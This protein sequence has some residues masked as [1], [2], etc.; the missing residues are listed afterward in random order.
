LIGSV[1]V[2]DRPADRQRQDVGGLAEIARG[3]VL[4]LA[5]A[6]ISAACMLG[7]TVIV[8][9]DFSRS[10]AGAF[11]T[12]TSLFVILEATAGLGAQS[13][14][15]YFIARLRS[16]GAESG[17]PALL[18]AAIIPVIASSIGA[19]L[20]LLTLAHPVARALLAGRELGG[21][22]SSAVADALRALA[23]ALPFAALLDTLLGASR[24]YRDMRPTVATDRVGRS[25]L[26]LLGTLAAAVLGAAALLAPL[27]AVAYVPSVAAAWIWLRR[28]RRR[29][30]AGSAPPL[31]DGG[32]GA[33]TPAGFWRFTAP[34][35]LA[36]VGQIVIQRLDIVLVGVIRGPV[37]AAVYTAATRFLVLGQLGNAAISMAA[38]PELSH[39]FALRDRRG[40]NAVYQATTA[41]L[42]LLTWPL[43]LLAIVYGPAI[44]SIFGQ[45]YRAGSTVMVIL[46]L[47][48]L[49]ATGCGQVDVVLTS[50]GRSALSLANGLVAVAVNV[51]V[52]LVLIPRYG[53]T[54]AAIGWAAAI[55]ASNLIP[56]AQLARIVRVHPFG[57]GTV[58]ACSLCALSFGVLPVL[59][60]VPFGHGPGA[61]LVSVA[62]GCVA[63][64]AGL[65]RWREPLQ[66][67]TIP[68]LR[69]SRGTFF[70]PSLARK[71]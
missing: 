21:A 39:L 11:F 46:G 8:T 14:L 13:G 17:I 4:N 52:D 40:A 67:L 2:Q 33:V 58:L 15:V 38:Q 29:A 18:R 65:W 34:R 54:G 56:L 48:M 16:T 55:A 30:V 60:R 63:L 5:G 42:V 35:A 6:A 43:Y 59:V 23:A 68:R 53:I 70:A 44:L 36:T 47:A 28:I 31:E 45:S 7:L 26:Q 51:C 66:L 19:A 12:A 61:A 9:R 22:T 1:L 62:S 10:V 49:L 64:A 41:W 32:L 24:G 57:T 71:P 50:T 37:D 25:L 20:L 69:G 27:W 3:S